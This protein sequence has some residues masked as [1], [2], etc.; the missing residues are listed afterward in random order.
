MLII[1]MKN[2]IHLQQPTQ[3]ENEKENSYHL[4]SKIVY[5]YTKKIYLAYCLL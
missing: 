3:M 5:M 4:S 2:H 1:C